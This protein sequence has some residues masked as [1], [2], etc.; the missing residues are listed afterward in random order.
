VPRQ[1]IASEREEG[2]EEDISQYLCRGKE[3]GAS[4]ILFESRLTKK[5]DTITRSETGLS[6]LRRIIFCQWWRGGERCSIRDI[7]ECQEGGKRIDGNFGEG[8]RM[9]E[10]K[11]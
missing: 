7:L 6:F 10:S 4:E 2:G 9:R 8:E 1:G 11:A 5:K 3:K